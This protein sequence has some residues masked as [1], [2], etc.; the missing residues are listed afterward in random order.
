MAALEGAE[1]LTLLEKM[2]LYF[3]TGKMLGASHF[4]PLLNMLERIF[5]LKWICYIVGMGIK[6]FNPFCLQNQFTRIRKTPDTLVCHLH[7]DR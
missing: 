2:C 4:C 7:D 5:I 3:P 6:N 1:N